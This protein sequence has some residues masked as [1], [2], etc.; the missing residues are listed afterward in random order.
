[1]PRPSKSE[2]GSI[3]VSAGIDPEGRFGCE[4]ALWGDIMSINQISG[5]EHPTSPN[6]R[7]GQGGAV[8]LCIYAEPLYAGEAQAAYFD[9]AWLI[10]NPH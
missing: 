7:A 5:E 10:Q 8:T 3:K 9:N 2:S 1:M 4:H 6:V